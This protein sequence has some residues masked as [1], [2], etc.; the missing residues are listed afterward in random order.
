MQP[1]KIALQNFLSYGD[2]EVGLTGLQ[3]AA[4]LGANGAGKS[5][6]ATDAITWPLYGEGRYKDIDRYIRQGQENAVAELQFMLA[7]E[8]Y[9]VI[10]TRSNKGRGKST[11]ELARRNGADWVPMSG[12]GIR[13]TQDK[14][15]DLLRMDYQTFVSSCVLLQGEA[16]RFTMATPG[17]RMAIFS[18]IIGLDIYNC[19]LEAARAKTR[20]YRNQVTVKRATVDNLDAELSRWK[21]L[22]TQERDLLKQKRALTKQV[23][24]LEIELVNKEKQV[25]DLRVKAARGD[26]LKARNQQIQAEISE[27]NSKLN[28]LGEKGKRLQQIIER[29]DEIRQKAAELEATRKQLDEC[30]IKAVRYMQLSNDV[31]KLNELV[32]CFDKHREGEAAR[33]EVAIKNNRVQAGLL[34]QVPCSGNM[35][36]GCELLKSARDAAAELP[37]L[38]SRM[39]KLNSRENPNV[40]DWKKASQ[41]LSAVGYDSGEHEELRDK[42]IALDKW[43]RVLPE[44][45]QAESNMTYLLQQ[46]GDLQRLQKGLAEELETVTAQLAGIEALAEGLRRWEGAL[47]GT[48][49]QLKEA[50]DQEQDIGIQLG[51][52]QARLKDLETK[53]EQKKDLEAEA[54]AVSKEEHLFS[55]LARAYKEIPV[56]IM[57]NALP[58]VEDLGNELLGRL[59]GGRISVRFETQ[60]EAKTTGTVSDT[61]DIIVGDELGERPYEGWS[62]AERFDVD[63]SIRLA[64][65]KFLAKR[66]GAKIETL[67]IDEGASCLD[68]QGREHFTQAISEIA[69]EFKLVLCITHIDELKEHFPQQLIVSKTPEGSRVEVVA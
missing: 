24:D 57:E 2:V 8:T 28:A 18:Q 38:E 54:A 14:I 21:E 52:V 1:T 39:E 43:A 15:R 41:A 59:T 62:G 20:D 45:E 5:S 46:A 26:D 9:R 30:E 23:A 36:A 34:E 17:E 47:F 44:L 37:I 49:Q 22:Q 58:D 60:K 33:L 19:L 6:I 7:G 25:N 42:V 50:Q 35:Q 29:G 13:E 64:I 67:I 10:R 3:L 4:V 68:A 63:L 56:L 65:S 69:K 16:D 61:L 55:Q 51:T 12:T 31:Q 11:L 48:R 53:A 40:V 66:A 27:I 32:H